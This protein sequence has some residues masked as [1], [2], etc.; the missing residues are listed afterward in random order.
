MEI[1]LERGALLVAGAVLGGQH[2]LHGA[3]IVPVHGD[4]DIGGEQGGVPLANGGGQGN[5]LDPCWGGREREGI[6][7]FC[8]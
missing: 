7:Y 3:E 5:V 4:D 6:F 2:V 1:L 8:R